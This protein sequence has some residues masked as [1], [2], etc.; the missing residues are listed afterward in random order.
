MESRRLKPP[1]NAYALYAFMGAF[2]GDFGEEQPLPPNFQLEGSAS[3]RLKV[4]QDL[5]VVVNA[6]DSVA[7]SNNGECSRLYESSIHSFMQESN[8]ANLGN[9]PGSITQLLISQVPALLVTIENSFNGVD[10]SQHIHQQYRTGSL[11]G[12]QK[13]FMQSVVEDYSKD[14]LL[15]EL[16]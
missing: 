6:L 15:S 10:C 9:L 4:Y 1:T 14:E 7:L 13:A 11:S 3:D 5:Q 16:K 2:D 12:P 8:I